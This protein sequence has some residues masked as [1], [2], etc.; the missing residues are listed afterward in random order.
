MT[1]QD[2]C[3]IYGVSES[4]VTTNFPRVRDSILKKHNVHLI[5]L[6]RGKNAT[7]EIQED[8][9]ALTMYEELKHEIV[10][11]RASIQ[12]MAFPFHVLIGIVITPML[13][14]RG[15]YIDF[16][17]YL[18]TS[19]SESNI[20][21]LKQAL[22][23]LQA[24]DYISYNVDKTNSNY[25]VA[26]IY[27]QKEEEMKIGIDMIR[28]CKAIAD[29]HNKQSWIPL[30]K[31]WIGAQMLAEREFFKMGDL[32]EL[33]GLSAYQVREARKLLEGDDIFRTT[34]AYAAFDLCLG[35]HIELNGFYN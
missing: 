2:V 33:T 27:R 10:L 4:A 16:L 8:F 14:F 23:E 25:F 21:L 28:R 5:K 11:D 29:E 7:Y 31:V 18:Q 22:E 32:E 35:S 3:E 12:L 1:L 15:S 13:V 30:F 9:R 17:N 20:E 34:R 6:G 26:A 19:T 24:A